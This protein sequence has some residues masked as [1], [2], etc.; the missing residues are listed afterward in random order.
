MM[1]SKRP[2]GPLL[3]TLENGEEECHFR[4]SCTFRRNEKSGCALEIFVFGIWRAKRLIEPAPL[5]YFGVSKRL[6]RYHY[7]CLSYIIGTLKFYQACYRVSEIAELQRNI[8]TSKHSKGEYER[9]DCAQN[10]SISVSPRVST[11]GDTM[12][13]CRAYT[14]VWKMRDSVKRV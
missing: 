4:D 6:V 9:T 10:L 7:F 11:D 12:I 3:I 14:V 2:L 5:W 1:Y 13:L 8:T